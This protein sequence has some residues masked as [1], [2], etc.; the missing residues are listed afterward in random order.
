[1]S[2]QCR[3]AGQKGGAKK[4]IVSEQRKVLGQLDW[5]TPNHVQAPEFGPRSNKYY[6]PIV[7]NTET[8]KHTHTHYMESVTHIPTIQS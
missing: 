2:C 8:Q 3:D 7:E 5:M 1:M 4:K 6:I